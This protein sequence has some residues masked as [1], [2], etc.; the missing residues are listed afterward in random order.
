MPQQLEEL[1]EHVPEERLIIDHEHFH[2]V[3]APPVESPRS[4]E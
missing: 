3:V 4:L 1:G 2:F